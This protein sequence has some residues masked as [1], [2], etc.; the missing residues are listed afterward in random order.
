MEWREMSSSAIARVAYDET[1]STLNVEFESGTIYEY[2]DVPRNIYEELL[3]AESAG[4]YF[5]QN[6]RDVY[7]FDR[8]R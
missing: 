7:R 5:A 3:S 4:S 2:F 1:S 6:I 8:T